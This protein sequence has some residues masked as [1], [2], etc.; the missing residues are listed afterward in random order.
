M[1]LRLPAPSSTR[2]CSTRPSSGTNRWAS[3]PASRPGTSR[4]TRSCS[5]SPTRWRLGAVESLL[6]VELRGYPVGD[7]SLPDTEVGPLVSEKQRDRVRSYID[8]GIADGARLIVG[9]VDAPDGLP[10]GYYVA[11]TI[12]SDVDPAS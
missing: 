1:L 4:S 2:R 8:N 10:T 11:P 9:G 7:P 6:P 5:R 3:W 12:F